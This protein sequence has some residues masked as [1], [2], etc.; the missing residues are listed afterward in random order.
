MLNFW[1]D[2]GTIEN[3]ENACETLPFMDEKRLII[4]KDNPSFKGGCNREEVAILLNILAKY[5]LPAAWFSGKRILT[6]E[7]GSFKG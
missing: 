4:V 1:K 6:G 7:R 3:I 5:L 2:N